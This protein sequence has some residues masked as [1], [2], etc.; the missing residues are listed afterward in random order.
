MHCRDIYTEGLRKTTKSLRIAAVPVEI[1]IEHLPYAS[2]YP[3]SAACS[4]CSVVVCER[5]VFG[6]DRSC[7]RIPPKSRFRISEAVMC[8]S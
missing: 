3:S 4:V 1:R 2:N 8:L 7:D 6:L 5:K